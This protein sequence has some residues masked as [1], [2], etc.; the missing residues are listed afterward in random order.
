MSPLSRALPVVLACLCT[1]SAATAQTPA[2]PA[3]PVSAG[4]K[5]M[6]QIVSGYIT[7]SADK[8]DEAV[9]AFKPTPEV[10]SFGQI[11][12]HLAD[13]NFA[14]C[15]AAQ[16][17]KPPMEGIEKSKTA[18]ADLVKVLADSFAYCG[19]IQASLT[20]E[21]GAE[22]MPFFGQKMARVSILD[23]NTAHNYEHYGN[24]VT[25]MRL[26]GIVPPSSE[27]PPAK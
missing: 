16:G 20:D 23:F 1:V 5:A 21:K 3:N 15:A 11:I 18:K 9:Y 25:Y 6:F 12:G 13:D 24:L 2:A 17:E 19:R 26:K 8:V 22:V 7:R 10:R 14:I 27:K 4:S